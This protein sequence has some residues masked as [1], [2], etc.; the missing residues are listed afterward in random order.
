MSKTNYTV[1]ECDRCGKK[2]SFIVDNINLTGWEEIN[3]PCIILS[4]DGR[5]TVERKEYRTK[6]MCGECAKEHF[7]LITKWFERQKR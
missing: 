4:C 1:Y 2:E 5:T 6:L 7:A 3:I